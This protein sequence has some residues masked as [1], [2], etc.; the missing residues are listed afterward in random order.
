MFKLALIKVKKKYVE[1]GV[2]EK[3]LRGC[4]HLAPR[5]LILD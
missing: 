5:G 1:R 2:E 4:L 3:R